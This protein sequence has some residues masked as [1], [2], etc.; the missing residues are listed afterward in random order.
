MDESRQIAQT[1]MDQIKALDFWA[2]GA[3]GS[4]DFVALKQYMKI[5]EGP[6]KGDC[7]RG[8]LRFKIRTPKY[9]T[10]TWVNIYLTVMDTYTIEVASVR[11]TQKD[12]RVRKTLC[13]AEDVYCFDLVTVIDSLIEK[14]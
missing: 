8:G 2:L 6:Y 3:W 11:M 7:I 1:I 4:H 14:K 12:G 10:A 5:E 13:T 9:P